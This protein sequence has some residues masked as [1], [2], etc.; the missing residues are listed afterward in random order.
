MS[1]LKED[2][3]SIHNDE[4]WNFPLMFVFLFDVFRYVNGPLVRGLY[5]WMNRVREAPDEDQRRRHDHLG[6]VV[7]A[8][9]VRVLLGHRYR[10]HTYRSDIN[11]IHREDN[12]RSVDQLP[13]ILW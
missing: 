12:S 3:K 1:M 5:L 6:G 10:D 7:Y 13:K 8:G 4:K 2:L 9:V 11:D